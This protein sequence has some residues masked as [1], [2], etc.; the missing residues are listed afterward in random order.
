MQFLPGGEHGFCTI[1]KEE[2]PH[3]PSDRV[4]RTPRRKNLLLLQ[5]YG[6]GLS[7]GIAGSGFG[8]GV[9]S[10]LFALVDVAGAF[11]VIVDDALF[12]VTDACRLGVL[13]LSVL[14]AAQG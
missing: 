5:G 1:G 13:F 2:V 11:F 14:L 8:T 3:G 4:I 6:T 7:P 12:A 10:G 9:A